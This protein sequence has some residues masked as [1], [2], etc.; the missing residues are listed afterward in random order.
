MLSNPSTCKPVV[1]FHWLQ[2]DH[3]I[4]LHMESGVRDKV[5]GCVHDKK[6]KIKKRFFLRGLIRTDLQWFYLRAT[7]VPLYF[8]P[9]LIFFDHLSSCPHCFPHSFFMVIQFQSPLLFY[10]WLLSKQVLLQEIRVKNLVSMGHVTS[11]WKRIIGINWI[12]SNV[13]LH[14]LKHR[15]WATLFS[16]VSSPFSTFFTTSPSRP[17]PQAPCPSFHAHAQGSSPLFLGLRPRLLVPCLAGPW[18][19]QV[20][21]E[22]PLGT[23]PERGTGLCITQWHPLSDIG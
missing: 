8:F 16:T 7:W 20:Q 11:L 12:L 15:S 10:T 1:P 6:K 14:S 19:Q 13:L 21:G 23:Q 2:W 9:P 22:H 17:T 18:V 4:R 5:S 3:F